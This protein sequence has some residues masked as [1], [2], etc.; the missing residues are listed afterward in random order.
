MTG[1][2]VDRETELRTLEHEADRDQPT[3]ILVHGRRRVGKTYLLQNAWGDRRVFYY[4]AVNSTPDQNRREL[5][6]ELQLRLDGSLQPEDYPN[7]RTAF[8]LFGKVAGD[9]PLIVVLDEFQ[10]LLDDKDGGNSEIV[11]TLNA[12]WESS[13]SD[14]DITLV[15]CG[16]EV[17]T[18]ES[19]AEQGALYG[20]L[21][22]KLPLEP[23]NYRQ[24]AGML[25]GRP[26][27]ERA[28]LYGI[29][30]G[31]PDFLDVVEEGVPLDEVVRSAYLDRS[32]KVYLQMSNLIEQEEGIREPGN[33]R[34]VLAAVASGRTKLNEIG[35]AAGFDMEAGGEDTTRRVLTTLLNLKYVRQER[36]FDA[37]QT[38]PW[39]YHL[40]D[41]ALAFWY[42]FVHR[43]RSLLQLDETKQVWRERIEP[44]LNEY[45]GWHVFEGMVEEAFEVCYQE[46]GF[47]APD[48]WARWVGK[49]RNRDDKEIDIVCR[50]ANDRLLTGEVKW[51]SSPVGTNIH[52]KLTADLQDLA[53]SGQGWARKALDPTES[54]GHL[55]V[56]AHGFTDEFRQLE[57][58][59][60]RV[61]LITLEDMYKTNGE[62]G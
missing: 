56:S 43:S 8:R 31:T 39:R 6:Q 42:R 30:G 28:Y 46:W 1:K 24:A 5:L 38:T 13:L 17:S 19:I 59:N 9:E 33:Y 53:A 61:H 34:A 58:G 36:N 37:G 55:Y 21:D 48:D 52:N 27:R 29:F 54:E 10:Y 22:R 50:L 60:P 51:S 3:L 35:Q 7:W 23:F 2:L 40:A 12:V 62:C 32:G 20:R 18:M 57:K 49:D 26:V 47:P 16:S 14:K 41:N 4:L 44:R 15:L 25:K 11:S 45:M